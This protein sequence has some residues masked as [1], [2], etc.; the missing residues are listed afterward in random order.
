VRGWIDPQLTDG[1]TRKDGA[2]TFVLGPGLL[3]R[4]LR[5]QHEY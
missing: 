3:E 5:F 1:T 2:L 4:G